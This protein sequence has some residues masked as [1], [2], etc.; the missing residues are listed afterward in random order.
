MSV[1]PLHPV[2]QAYIEPAFRLA[3]ATWPGVYDALK[4]NISARMVRGQGD[5]RRSVLT[6]MEG[7]HFADDFQM[8]VFCCLAQRASDELLAGN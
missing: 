6:L 8:F 1:N 5:W 2:D 3:Q 7:G 4:D